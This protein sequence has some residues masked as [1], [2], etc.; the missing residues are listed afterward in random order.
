MANEAAI[1]TAG[2][3]GGE[4]DGSGLI[5]QWERRARS[6]WR[7]ASMLAVSVLIHAM[8]FYALQVAYTPTGTQLPPP[9]H[10]VLVPLDQPENAPLA[11]WLTMNDPALTMRPATPAAPQVLASLG[12]RYVPSYNAA[13]P[14]FKPLD[15]MENSVNTVP[16]KASLPGPVPVPPP[17]ITMANRNRD[18][19]RTTRVVLTG[20]IALPAGA[21]PP[22]VRFVAS[23]GTNVLDPTVF[24]VG[25]RPESGEPFLFRQ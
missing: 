4:D 10:V 19:G 23:E 22:P 12:F 14:P 21:A 20:P 16:P 25:V 18:I 6:H 9:A 17:T 24:M 13:Q 11:R 2:N 5:F 7:L 3:G 8:S 15:P 1:V